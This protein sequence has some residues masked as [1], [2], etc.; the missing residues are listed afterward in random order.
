MQK[1][2][3]QRQRVV[4]AR[5]GGGVAASMAVDLRVR[6]KPYQD[7]GLLDPAIASAAT[8]ECR[9]VTDGVAS[10]GCVQHS[11][12]TTR[13]PV[14]HRPQNALPAKWLFP[15]HSVHRRMKAQAV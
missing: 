9:V 8:G 7:L 1:I 14:R 11:V 13:W 2:P 12:C 10:R 4:R 3:N 6:Q 15:K 5:R